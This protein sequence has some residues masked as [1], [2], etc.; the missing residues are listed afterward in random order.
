[1]CCMYVKLYTCYISFGKQ[2]DQTCVVDFCMQSCPINHHMEG[3]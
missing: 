1:M 2:P 3:Q